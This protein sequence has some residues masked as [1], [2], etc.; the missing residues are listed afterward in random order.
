MLNELAVDVHVNAI[1]KGFWNEPK[2]HGECIALMHSE[3]SEALEELRKGNDPS[4]LYFVANG[5]KWAF[6]EKNKKPEGVPAEL[7]DCIIRI[8]DFCGAHEIDIDE[9]IAVKMEYNKTRPVMHGKK[10]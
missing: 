6:V 2:S 3:L 9:A 1:E 5:E 4:Y 10:F 8:L 7:A